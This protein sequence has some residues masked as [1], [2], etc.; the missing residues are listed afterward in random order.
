[1]IGLRLISNTI[2]ISSYRREMKNSSGRSRTLS[3]RKSLRV[4]EVS[5]FAVVV[6]VA[7]HQNGLTSAY[8]RCTLENWG[9]KI[10]GNCSP[11][12]PLI[13]PK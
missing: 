10:L 13:F 9:Y 5:F 4:P 1:M 2:N 11:T 12:H 3:P 6:L 7:S 8:L